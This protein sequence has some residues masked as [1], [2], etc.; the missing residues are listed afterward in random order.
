MSHSYQNFTWI[1]SVIDL[2]DILIM[3][4]VFPTNK[5]YQ[6]IVVFITLR[7]VKNCIHSFIHSFS[8]PATHH[9]MKGLQTSCKYGYFM[10]G[11]SI[12]QHRNSTMS[13]G[14][15]E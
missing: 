14:M 7:L 12:C 6:C 5:R 2:V 8:Y 9:S 13:N 11:V 3:D 4:L 15:N 1:V 10:A